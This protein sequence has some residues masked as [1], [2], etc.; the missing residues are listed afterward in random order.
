M[1]SIAISNASVA[2]PVGKNDSQQSAAAT[3]LGFKPSIEQVLSD[4]PEVTGNSSSLPLRN[5]ETLAKDE[6]EKMFRALKNVLD[7]FE[8]SDDESAENESFDVKELQSSLEQADVDAR[9][10]ERN[11]G[12][13]QNVHTILCKLWSVN[14]GLL[15]QAAEALANGSRDREF[16]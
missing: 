1:A 7:N 3:A 2:L 5:S 4:L 10:G 12:P 13:L 14:S 8:P 15:G 16:F 6:Q 9:R 11:A